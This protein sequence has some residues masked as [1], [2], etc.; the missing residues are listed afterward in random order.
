MVGKYIFPVIFSIVITLIQLANA[1]LIYR[2]SKIS[3]NKEKILFVFFLISAIGWIFLGAT[4]AIYFNFSLA[5]A[6]F[7][8]KIGQVFVYLQYIIAAGFIFSLAE[9]QNRKIK[10]L[11][12]LILLFL[13][14]ALTIFFTRL[15]EFKSATEYKALFRYCVNINLYFMILIFSLLPLFGYLILKEVKRERFPTKNFFFLSIILYY[16]ALGAFEVFGVFE[17]FEGSPI[18]LARSI[19]YLLIPYSL[20]LAYKYY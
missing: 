10:N 20:Y 19:F 17:G 7:I 14:L 11:A 1:I 12:I 16:G 13:F 9:I 15:V 6:L 4:Q 3:S 2:F 8:Y 18:L 5:P